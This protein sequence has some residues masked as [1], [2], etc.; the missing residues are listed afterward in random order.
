MQLNAAVVRR[1]NHNLP[2]VQ[3]SCYT[4]AGPHVDHQA[5]RTLF[6]AYGVIP[7]FAENIISSSMTDDK[8]IV[9]FVSP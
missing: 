1:G 4:P 2:L 5:M 6:K 8:S 3:F 7:V 9:I